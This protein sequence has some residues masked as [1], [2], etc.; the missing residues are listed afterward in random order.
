M[1]EQ[2]RAPME[3]PASTAEHSRKV[4][5][6]ESGLVDMVGVQMRYGEY[7]SS[8][9]NSTLSLYNESSNEP[10]MKSGR[11]AYQ[12]SSS[13]LLVGVFPAF[14]ALPGEPQMH[15]LQLQT[16]HHSSPQTRPHWSCGWV[17]RQEQ[18][19]GVENVLLRL[20]LW[21]RNRADSIRNWAEAGRSDYRIQTFL[22]EEA[23][24]LP[25]LL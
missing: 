21:S 8:S 19:T 5:V 6:F 4:W 22:S 23:T 25:E 20:Q 1:R 18:M 12:N 3:A 2:I 7:R 24:R 14:C 15:G 11:R 13:W 10:P 9:R 16:F 17:Q